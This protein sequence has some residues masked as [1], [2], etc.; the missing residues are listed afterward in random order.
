MEVLGAK[1]APSCYLNGRC[2][3]AFATIFKVKSV[4][5]DNRHMRFLASP[6]HDVYSTV[7]IC[8][9]RYTATTSFADLG[10]HTCHRVRPDDD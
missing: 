5:N 10:G 9:G 6:S 1:L 8:N 7:I 3:Y 2:I 4:T